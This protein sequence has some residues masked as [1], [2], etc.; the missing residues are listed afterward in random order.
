[1][2]WIFLYLAG[3]LEIAW[4]TAMKMSDG[5]TRPGYSA[6]AGLTAFMSFWLLSQ[7]MRTLPLGTA[8]PLWVGIG[9]IGAFVIGAIYFGEAITPLRIGSACLI[10]VGIVGLRASGV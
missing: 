10:V 2:A 5:F 8:Y 6:L 9:A 4:A 7:A 1:M 3:L